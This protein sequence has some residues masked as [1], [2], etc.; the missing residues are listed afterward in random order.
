M[1]HLHCISFVKK[2][3]YSLFSWC[4][5]CSGNATYN[6]TSIDVCTCPE[7]NVTGGRCQPGDFCPEGSSAPIKCTAGYYCD[8]Y[9]L[10]TPKAQCSP[11]YYCPSG[12]TSSNPSSFVC[13]PGY[14]CPQ[15]SATPTPCPSGTFSNASGISNVTQCVDCTPGKSMFIK[16]KII[17]LNNHMLS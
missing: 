13:T 8:D 17:H 16:S 15:G 4:P 14:Y 2:K 1:L 9:E 10:A 11:G 12:Q 6:Y 5:V 7:F 3:N